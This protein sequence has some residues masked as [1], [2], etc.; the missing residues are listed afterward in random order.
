MTCPCDTVSYTINGE[1]I[2]GI[3]E[4]TDEEKQAVAERSSTRTVGFA[5]EAA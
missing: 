1:T 2:T 5:N 3:V 4:M